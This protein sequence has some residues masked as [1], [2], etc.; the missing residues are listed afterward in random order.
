[1]HVQVEC[2]SEN[3]K[4]RDISEDLIVDGKTILEWLLE[5]QG[6]KVWSGFI[7]LMI[8]ASRGLL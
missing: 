4:G 7:W 8:W 6:G 1:M 3:L 5:K 2:W